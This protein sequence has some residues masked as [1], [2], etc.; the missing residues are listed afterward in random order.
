MWASINDRSGSIEADDHM[1]NAS[2]KRGGRNATI[3]K[4]L[5]NDDF[6]IWITNP[7]S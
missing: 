3:I 5:R 1:Q 2:K 7:G 6:Q 4:N